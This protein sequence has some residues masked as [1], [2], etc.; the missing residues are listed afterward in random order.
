MGQGDESKSGLIPTLSKRDRSDRR[1]RETGKR[2]KPDKRARE[3]GQRDKP[4][5]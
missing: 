4:E 1:V 3:M 5:S 2:D